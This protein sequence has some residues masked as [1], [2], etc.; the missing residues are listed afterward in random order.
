M[1]TTTGTDQLSQAEEAIIAALNKAAADPRL[2]GSDPSYLLAL[3]YAVKVVRLEA[4]IVRES[5]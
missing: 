1:K 2:G 5:L 3:Q 4:S